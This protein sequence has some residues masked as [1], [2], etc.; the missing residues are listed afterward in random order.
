M[1][2]Y[3]HIALRHLFP[4]GKRFPVFTLMSVTGVVLGVA[5][6]IVVISVFDGFGHELRTKMMDTH[7]D[8]RV[9]S[10]GL[11]YNSEDLSSRLE[12]MEEIR[13]AVPYANG[14]IMLMHKN[15]PLAPVV[16]GIDVRSDEELAKYEA[17]LVD[18]NID[19]LDDDSILVSSGLAEQLNLFVEDEVEVYTPLMMLKLLESNGADVLLPRSVRI[20]GIYHTGWQRIDENTVVCTLRLMQ[21]L[22]NLGESAHGI[23]VELNDGYDS[24]EVAETIGESLGRPY[25]ARTW[26][27]SHGDYLSI[28]QLEKRMM[29]F[30]LFIIVIVASFSIMSSLLIFVIRKTRE[31]GLFASMGATPRQ[32]AACFCYQGLFIG[33]V[34]TAIGISLGLILIRFRDSITSV[35]SSMLQVADSMNQIYGFSSLPARIEV[36][37]VI[38][39]GFMSILVATLAGLIP[40]YKASR[41]DPVEALRSE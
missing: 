9:V 31:I 36:T 26:M 27:D 7:G 40:A 3:L 19:D 6:L 18:G 2:W 39:I 10:G 32:I 34:G 11:M 12:A 22:Y 8:L 28:I 14:M 21:D 16:E 4:Q 24:L 5:V 17:F 23:R 1:P 29:F 41:L 38:V 30:L 37:D 25:Y 20:A 35:I 13:S 15:Q 33:V